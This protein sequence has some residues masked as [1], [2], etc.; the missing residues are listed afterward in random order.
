MYHRSC[1]AAKLCPCR[2]S[3]CNAASGEGW[4]RQGDYKVVGCGAALL[5][6]GLQLWQ[7]GARRRLV[8][9]C[10]AVMRMWAGSALYAFAYG[11]YTSKSMCSFS[12]WQAVER[13]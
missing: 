11:W 1:G 6:G 5:V 3:N 2:H 10:V 9:G 7:L 12:D 4:N 8:G 13:G